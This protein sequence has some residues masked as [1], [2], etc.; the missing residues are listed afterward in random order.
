MEVNMEQIREF[1]D[2]LRTSPRAK[3]LLG[4]KDP[5]TKEEAL[6]RYVSAAE[7]LGFF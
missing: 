7:A 2:A 1:M 4:T 5:E 6:R 3:E